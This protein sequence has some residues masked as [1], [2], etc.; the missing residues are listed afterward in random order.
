MSQVHIYKYRVAHFVTCGTCSVLA[1]CVAA[2][3]GM[4]QLSLLISASHANVAR[5]LGLMDV[6]LS[7]AARSW[8]HSDAE[9]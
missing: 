4:L 5:F 6:T 9:A 7:P 8:N 1:R 2:F 3:A